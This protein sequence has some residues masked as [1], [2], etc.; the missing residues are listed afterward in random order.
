M[1]K[2]WDFLKKFESNFNHWFKLIAAAVSL[3]LCA[4]LCVERKC[5]TPSPGGEVE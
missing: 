5:L 2:R 1:G 4:I 3:G